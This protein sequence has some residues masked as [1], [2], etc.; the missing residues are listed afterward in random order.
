MKSPHAQREE[1][2][3]EFWKQNKVFEKTLAKESPKGEFVFYE[4]PPTANGKPGIHHVE[5]RSFKDA[6]PRYKTMRGFHV[7]RR[8]GWDTHGLPVELQVEKQ[9]GLKSKKEIEQYGVAEFNKQCKQSVFEYIDLWSKFTERVGYWADMEDAYFTFDNSYIESL[10]NIVA[11]IEGKNLLYKDYR[12]APWCT[13][14]GT[15]LSSH[16][17][18]QGYADVKD[19][20]VFVKFPIINSQFSNTEKTFILAWTTT[21]W[22]LPGNVGLAVGKEIE[23]VKVK[24]G[25]EVLILAET[26]LGV[27][28]EGYEVL[29]KVKGSDLVGLSYEPLFPFLKDILPESEKSKLPNAFKVYAA[30]FVTT[31]DGTGVVHTAVMYGADD[32]AL[33]TTENLPKHHM[34]GVDGNFKENMGFLSGRYVKE[35]D[36]NGKPLLAVDIIDDLKKRGLFFSQENYKHSYPHCWRCKTPLIYYARDSWYI[37]M[38]KLRSELVNEN[39]KINWEPEYI[40]EGRFGEWLREIKDWAISRER[41][42][43]TPLPVW[44]TED[45]KERLV[46]D[47][48]ATLKKHVKKSG[49]TYCVMR[50]GQTEA[51][52]L[53]I[54]DITTNRNLSEEGRSL[55]AS[56]I[57]EMKKKEIKPDLIFVSPYNRTLETAK[58]V[59]EAFGIPESALIQD[60]RL[61]EW[62]M[63][64]GLDGTLLSDFFDKLEREG[65]KNYHYALP[66]GESY[67]DVIKRTAEFLY[68]IEGKYQDKQIL[69]VSHAG[70]IKTMCLTASGTDLKGADKFIGESRKFDNAEVRHLDFA[71]LPHNE[72][73]ELDLHK[74]YIDGVELVSESVQKLTRVKEV[75][76]VWFDSG[77]MPFAQDH[78]PFEN[79]EL[80]DKAGFPADYICEAIDQTRGW[81][82]TLH[83]VGT[84][85]G[86]GRAYKNVIC[87]GH[88]LDK[89]GKKMSKSLGNIVDP[90]EQIEKF[91][92][93]A[94]RLWMY[95]VN[96]PGESKNYDEK[97]VDDINKKVFN[98]VTNVLS[99]YELY[100]DRTLEWD[101]VP[102]SS[103]VLDQWIMVRLNTLVGE[104]TD[105][106]DSYK[107]LE[108]VRAIR[109]FIDDL[110]TWYLQLSRDRFRTEDSGAK[111]TLYYVL[112]TL[113]KLLAPF[114]PF[115]AEDLYQ[116][117]RVDGDVLSV[118]LEAWP[119]AQEASLLS[120]ILGR[121]KS[122]ELLND[123]EKT[124]QIVTLGLDARMK[125]NVKVRQPLARLVIKKSFEVSEEL[126]NLVKERVNVKEVVFSDTEVTDAV[127]DTTITEALREEGVVRELIRFVQDLRK[128]KGM[129]P[130]DKIILSIGSN[131]S[132]GKVLEKSAWKNMLQAAVLAE[133]L[134]INATLEGE[135][136]TVED[137]EFVITL[138]I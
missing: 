135:K 13:R 14:C 49:N 71:P 91:G 114:A 112:R 119:E 44:T 37:G 46:V 32:F 70:P 109:E 128:Q 98:L 38:S 106:L 87:L 3:L 138:R 25:D 107:L 77:A 56:R 105:S 76:D 120:K 123:M 9:L 59:A 61:V 35:T 12:V 90:W 45:G 2:V 7:R 129:T 132:G 10:W 96:Q 36:E 24:V 48:I 29:S 15:T 21:P 69:I 97:T 34:I 22:T 63:G 92:I 66:G 51:N 104:M 1:K 103:H 57:A 81:F 127:L 4:G 101:T 89:N 117:L 85:L 116:K 131:E 67:A 33:G 115:Y 11:K 108:P 41:Y 124:R 113:A 20:S 78:Y 94:I 88:L 82:Y 126:Q 58:M 93:D 5:S 53:G 102:Q 18:A 95:S 136:L 42:W 39:E 86:R 8:A 137:M 17:L 79:K 100:R 133:T 43:G 122:A 80:L 74:P 130:S 50:H 72:N 83:A 47:S 110:S 26:R 55:A 54:I 27:L 30:D 111:Q 40:K 99:F 52:V 118:H 6:V 31:S 134:D 125:A 23:Y 84:L 16:E 19:L 64:E 68:E 73:F 60:K 28:P 75:M 121:D 65:G 62:N